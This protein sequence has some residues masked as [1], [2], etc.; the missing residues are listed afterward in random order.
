M[1]ESLRVGIAGLG[2]VGASVVRV[3]TEKAAEL[4]RQCG[5]TIT[6]TAVAVSDP[7]KGKFALKDK[8]AAMAAAFAYL[9]KNDAFP[10]DNDSDDDE[11]AFG[12][13]AFEDM[14]FA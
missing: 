11:C 4:T 3:L 14:G 10:E 5:R 12:D 13:D 9:R 7:D 2:T 1:A 6:V 8:D